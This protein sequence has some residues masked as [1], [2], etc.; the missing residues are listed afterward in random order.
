MSFYIIL[1][2]YAYDQDGDFCLTLYFM[3]VCIKT[4]S[5]FFATGSEII[6]ALI[7]FGYYIEFDESFNMKVKSVTI[8]AIYIKIGEPTAW[9]K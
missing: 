5:E 6:E 8:N 1:N 9:V 2:K 3:C 4:V 7:C